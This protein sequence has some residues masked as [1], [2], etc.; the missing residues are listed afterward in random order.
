[1]E[2]P[3]LTQR[4]KNFQICFRPQNK[5]FG[6]VEIPK[7]YL[8]FILDFLETLYRCRKAGFSASTKGEFKEYLKNKTLIFH[9]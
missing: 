5:V 9:L 2:R 3:R 6:P 7:L 1:M 4:Q 8:N